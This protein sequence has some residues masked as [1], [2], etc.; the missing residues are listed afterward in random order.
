[1]DILPSA[2][3]ESYSTS[4]ILNIF[5]VVAMFHA[6]VT[7]ESERYD[8]SGMEL[9]EA[10]HIALLSTCQQNSKN[11]LFEVC[12]KVLGMRRDREGS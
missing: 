4:Y 10:M 3:E 7:N 8:D 9:M 6:S 2:V 1:M 12:L 11:K 5:V